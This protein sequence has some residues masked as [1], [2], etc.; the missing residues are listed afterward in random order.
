MKTPDETP[1]AED[2]AIASDMANRWHEAVAINLQLKALGVKPVDPN[3]PLHLITA[4]FASQDAVIMA[5]VWELQEYGRAVIGKVDATID[6]GN[7][8]G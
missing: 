6:G 8:V 2:L 3:E 5:R 1:S 7:P 4:P